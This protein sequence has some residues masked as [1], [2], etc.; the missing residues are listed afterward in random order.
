ME[1]IL[2]LLA[3][4][5]YALALTQV[6]PGLSHNEQIPARRVHL[7]AALA[8]LLHLFL[9]KDLILAEEGQNLSLLNVASLISFII[10]A[11]ATLASIRHRVWFLLPV[12]YSFAAINLC[13]STLLPSAF[14]TH[15]E[16]HLTILLHISLALFA[17]A[18]L[19]IACLYAVQLAYLDNKLRNKKK[20]SLNPNLPPLMAVER[21]L[22]KII[23]IGNLLLTATLF[24]GFWFVG[25]M[26]T[27]GK[28]HKAILSMSAWVIY[29]ALLWGHYQRGWRGR[30][31][32]WFSI[33]G[34]FLLSLAYF[35]S[36]FVR[37]F[38]IGL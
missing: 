30:R 36:R 3:A 25:D 27:E 4:S 33:I 31:V 17:Y 18:T 13:A 16:A 14:I 6:M 22:F 23:L 15:L 11:I 32:I 26:F 38:I 21:Q 20:L 10:S 24:T 5:S 29:T 12:V 19:M 34:A 7:F 1:M 9:L 2:A 28:A 8:L 35:G 37:E